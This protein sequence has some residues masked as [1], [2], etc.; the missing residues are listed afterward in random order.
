[1]KNIYACRLVF[2]GL[3]FLSS[4]TTIG[5]TA[6]PPK[7]YSEKTNE[8]IASVPLNPKHGDVIWGDLKVGMTAE[9]A[10]Q[11]IPNSKFDDKWSAGGMIGV[12]AE[13]G[14]LANNKIKV[15]A[16]INGPFNTPSNLYVLFDEAGRLDGVVILTLKKNLPKEVT[17]NYG[18]V[19]YNLVEYKEASKLIISKYAP[20][21]LGQRK[22]APKFGK[23]QMDSFGSVGIAKP[24]G[25]S[26]AVGVG[27]S[28]GS[29]SP[30][31]IIQNYERAGYRS[32]LSVRSAYLG[33]YNLYSGVAVFMAI[34]ARTKDDVIEDF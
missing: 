31:T 15:G 21:E 18:A 12:M 14:I 4:C 26:T 11:A 34:Q 9:E 29:I 28:T 2:L 5:G 33:L 19:G 17:A 24:L 16:E 10:L 20:I 6:T 8:N 7:E 27:I 30:A 3:M 23:D 32:I 22:G 13:A 25:K 1:M